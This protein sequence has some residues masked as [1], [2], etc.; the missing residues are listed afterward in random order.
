MVK[1]MDHLAQSDMAYVFGNILQFTGSVKLQYLSDQFM[2]LNAL[3]V[4]CYLEGLSK[5]DILRAGQEFVKGSRGMEM[6]GVEVREE[7]RVEAGL[8]GRR[9]DRI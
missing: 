4:N 5:E 8:T 9:N 2:G 6:A 7:Y 3:M 1:K